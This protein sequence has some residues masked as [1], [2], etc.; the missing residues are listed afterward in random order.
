MKWCFI[1]GTICWFQTSPHIC[2]LSYLKDNRPTSSLCSPTFTRKQSK[3]PPHSFFFSKLNFYPPVFRTQTLSDGPGFRF[4]LRITNC[5]ILDKSPHL[6]DSSSPPPNGAHN[7]TL[8]HW[9]VKWNWVY[10]VLS[11]IVG[12]GHSSTNGN[13][14]SNAEISESSWTSSSSSAFT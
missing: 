11:V 4:H 8:E 2:P 3:L 7:T 13:Q 14:K 6:L 9:K 1:L 12:H 10:K 5:V